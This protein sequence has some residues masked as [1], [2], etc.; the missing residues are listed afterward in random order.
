[1]RRR[2]RAKL[3]SKAPKLVYYAALL[4]VRVCRGAR[5][6]RLMR[7]WTMTSCQTLTA[8]VEPAFSTPLWDDADCYELAAPRHPASPS[9]AKHFSSSSTSFSSSV[10]SMFELTNLNQ[11]FR[12]CRWENVFSLAVNHIVASLTVFTTTARNI[13]L[14]EAQM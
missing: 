10:L 14:Q 4:C 7:L 3:T 11:H 12:N 2:S 9:A 1:M 8:A 5:S 6:V 13:H